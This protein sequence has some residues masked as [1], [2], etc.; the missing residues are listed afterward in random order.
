MT[1]HSPASRAGFRASMVRLAGA[2]L[3]LA[4]VAGCGGPGTTP[5]ITPGTSAHP[6]AV[7]IVLKDY[8]YIP[9]VVDLVPGESVTL[10]VL[11]GGLVIHEA[12]FGGMDVQGAW[13]AAEAATTG[14]PPGPTPQVSVAPEVA[15]L[16]IVVRSG[17]RVDLPWTV[18]VD[19]ATTAARKG[20]WL[21][22]CHI[23]GH[24][25]AGMVV[26]VRFV[27]PD[28]RPLPTG[29]G[30]DPTTGALPAASAAS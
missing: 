8:S 6:R 25:A 17:E 20:G 2:G 24:W 9:A 23:P 14:A 28:G 22:G 21:V 11:N 26:P 10:Q 27:G 12:V 19:A 30:P 15:G 4:V 18:P 7:I 3:L 16:R 5:P 29:G 1:T 13:E